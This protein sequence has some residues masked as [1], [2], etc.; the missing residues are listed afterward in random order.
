[1]TSRLCAR[2][3]LRWRRA[4]LA[5]LAFTAVAL[6]SQDAMAQHRRECVDI[7]TATVDELQ[8]I[9]HIGEVRS[10]EIVRLRQ[11]RPFGSVD[12]LKRVN[13]IAEARLRDIKKQGLACV[14][15]PPKREGQP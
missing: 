1:M 5:T 15:Q 10:R 9:I 11:Q 12:Q 7:N 4:V 8:R 3:V 14:K 2:Q 13:G 6:V